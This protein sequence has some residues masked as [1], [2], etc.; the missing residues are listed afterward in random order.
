MGIQ[1]PG[2]Q[3]LSLVDPHS[4]SP[5]SPSTADR[6]CLLPDQISI[7]LLRYLPLL[8]FTIIILAVSTLRKYQT[9]TLGKSYDHDVDGERGSSLTASPESSYSSGPM[10]SARMP[11]SASG[12]RS[13]AGAAPTLRASSATFPPHTPDVI[14]YGAETPPQSAGRSQS[15]LLSAPLSGMSIADTHDIENGRDD[16]M[17]DAQ[18]ARY[19]SRGSHYLD[20]DEVG[21]DE[22]GVSVPLVG[23]I[24][25]NRNRRRW[26]AWTWT[27]TF[28]GRRARF[29]IGVP[30]LLEQ[31]LIRLVNRLGLGRVS[32]RR[33]DGGR[34]SRKGFSGGQT[35]PMS[36]FAWDFFSAAFVP[37]SLFIIINWYI[38]RS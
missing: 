25:W 23:R 32:G 11:G 30:P 2:F 9:A 35:N 33:G 14:V 20:G 37:I 5:N 27:F 13:G 19:R 16:D 15:G 8:I 18:M 22:Y 6:L 10:S 1:Q 38:L 34:L 3:L 26:M 12:S 24:P 36:I 17:M 29:T 28:R 31:T 21:D 7:Y 4:I